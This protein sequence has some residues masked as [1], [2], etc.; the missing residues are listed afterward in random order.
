MK[1]FG[2]LERNPSNESS[3]RAVPGHPIMHPPAP[4]SLAPAKPA[5]LASLTRESSSGEEI[6]AESVLSPR[7]GII[8]TMDERK[9]LEDHLRGK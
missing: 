8:F 3:K 6:V 4:V 5:S 7:R 2:C 1:L 9:R